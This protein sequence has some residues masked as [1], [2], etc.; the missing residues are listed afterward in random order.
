MMR[1]NGRGAQLLL[2]CGIASSIWYVAINVIVPM[3]WPSYSIVDHTVSELSAIGAPTRTFW[4]AIVLPYVLLFAAFGL[5]VRAVA[6]SS[7]AL[8]TAG[9]LVLFYCAFNAWWPPMH[10]RDVLAA[11]GGTLTDTLHLIWAGVTTALFLLMMACA[12]TAF[13]GAFR[14]I[15]ILSMGCLV[16]FGVLTAMDA[17][18]LAMGL[19]TP[20]IGIWERVDIGVF[21]VWVAAFALI[22]MRGEARNAQGAGLAQSAKP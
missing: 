11:G 3:Q 7:R 21:V 10:S 22:L 13:S 17:P 19:P 5:G 16:G 2:A 1:P 15:T 20:W 18:D 8:R 9:S 14:R 4:I 12:A 6:G